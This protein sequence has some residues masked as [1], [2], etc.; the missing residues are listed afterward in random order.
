MSTKTKDHHHGRSK[1]DRRKQK[2]S[3]HRR[4]KPTI[5][6]VR[7][8]LCVNPMYYSFAYKSTKLNT[9]IKIDLKTMA[10][11]NLHITEDIDQRS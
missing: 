10:N 1:E 5:A 2:S 7:E 8:V 11:R 3:H 6:D 9:I 4:L